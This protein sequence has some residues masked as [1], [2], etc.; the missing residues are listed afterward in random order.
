VF[1]G[2]DFDIIWLQKD[3]GVYVVNLFDTNQASHLLEMRYHSL[4][5]LLKHYCQV[6]AD[7]KFQLADWRL[8]M[9]NELIQNSVTMTYNLLKVTLDRSAEIS[10]QCYETFRYDPSGE[11][12]NGYQKLL[13]KW[14]HPLDRQQL[15]VFK[16]LHAWRDNKAREEDESLAYVLPNDIL[17]TLS[18]KMPDDS[19]DITHFCRNIVPPLVRENTLELVSL[20]ADAKN[21][22]L[23]SPSIFESQ[24]MRIERD[25]R[26]AT[27]NNVPILNSKNIKWVLDK[28]HPKYNVDDYKEKKSVLFGDF[29]I[30]NEMNE[31]SKKK[32]SE[33]LSNF[34]FAL[35]ILP[36]SI[37]YN[38]NR[39]NQKSKPIDENSQPIISPVEHIYVPPEARSTKSKGK[40]REVVVLSQSISKKRQ[41]REDDVEDV[42]II[43]KNEKTFVTETVT[44]VKAESSKSTNMDTS[45][46]DTPLTKAEKRTRKKMKAI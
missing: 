18:E 41:R 30:E 26:T 8:R 39:D 42:T 19:K 40:E 27:S 5:Y 36:K 7:K 3:F 32:V 22:V 44:P 28:S 15:A 24:P 11:G 29:Y 31:T 9:R 12:P 25:I 21:S 35:P 38:S 20:I 2:A 14:N 16:A 1:H 43:E 46:S 45:T 33:I 13:A 10:L 23:N 4:A 37:S 17:F 6:D 34:T